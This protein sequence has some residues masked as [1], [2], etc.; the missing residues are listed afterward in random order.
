M[1]DSNIGKNADLFAVIEALRSLVREEL[2]SEKE[3]K[4]C[5]AAFS[6]DYGTDVICSL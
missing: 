2:F 1:Q 3:A 5:V 4:K 6:L